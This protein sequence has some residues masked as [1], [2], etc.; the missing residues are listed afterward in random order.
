MNL[1]VIFLKKDGIFTIIAVGGSEDGKD[2]VAASAMSEG[3]R[4]SSAIAVPY[5]TRASVDKDVFVVYATIKIEKKGE[6]L[7]QFLMEGDVPTANDFFIYKQ[8]SSAQKKFEELVLKYRGGDDANP[9][10]TVYKKI[11]KVY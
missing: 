4:H 7:E 2:F 5:I 1:D 11:L 6:E 3:G 10:I 9:N 8:E